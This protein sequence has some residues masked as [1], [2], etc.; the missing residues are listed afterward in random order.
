MLMMKIVIWISS[1]DYDNDGN[2]PGD[3]QSGSVFTLSTQ[4]N[5]SEFRKIYSAVVEYN[6]KDKF[7]KQ[8]LS[9]NT[10]GGTTTPPQKKKKKE[11][12]LGT[13]L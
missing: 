10:H 4:K 7:S 12:G 13:I 3:F 1:I 9:H 6:Q 11:E 5:K 8:Y 2:V